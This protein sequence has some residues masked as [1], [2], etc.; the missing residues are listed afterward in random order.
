V[1]SL[2]DR[3]AVIYEGRVVGLFDAADTD[4]SQVG[5]LM[6]GGAPPA[7]VEPRDP[8]RLVR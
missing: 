6:T 2:A 7:T 8:A 4:V 3:V 1:L 5:L